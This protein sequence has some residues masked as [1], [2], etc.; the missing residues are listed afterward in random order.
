MTDE[1]IRAAVQAGILSEPQ[2]TRL[3]ALAESRA[4]QRAAMPSEDEPFEFFR[5]FSEIFVSLGLVITLIGVTSVTFLFAGDQGLYL[6]PFMVAAL[7]WGFAEY[8]TRIR[9][10][11][12]PS[13][14]L[15]VAF[16]GAI[17]LGVM[18]LMAMNTNLFRAGRE[19][20]VV[21]LLLASL[22]ML[23]WYAR[24]RLPF[25][26]F[27]LGCL[28]LATIYTALMHDDMPGID[29]GDTWAVFF[30][31]G[32]NPVFAI[33]TLLF[34]TVCFLIGMS[35]DM[36][37]PWRLG[38]RAATAFW[39]HLLA[40]PA[41]VNTVAL[42]LYRDGSGMAMAWLV[43]ALVLITVLA[44][45]IDRRSFL[46]AALAYIALVLFWMADAREGIDISW[47]VIV[48]ALGLGVTAIGTWWVALRGGL[49]RLLPEFPGK[50]RLPPYRAP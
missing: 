12:L 2:A 14:V 39:L 43:L 16:G 23:L 4:G 47:G 19:L 3:R 38:R 40:A 42:T 44:L 32:T 35:F 25:S 17:V 6:I 13:M 50:S 30:D 45:V 15:A 33:A 27:V 18:G 49:M 46:S 28:A 48:I 7:A 26:A 5:G 29:D 31:I 37:D 21:P 41:L 8:L 10:M 1:D 36:S 11:N 20:F 9:R 24:F 22:G 34:G